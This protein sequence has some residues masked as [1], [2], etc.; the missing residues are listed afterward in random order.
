M[1][2]IVAAM[3]RAFRSCQDLDLDVRIVTYAGQGLGSQGRTPGRHSGSTVAAAGE[4]IPMRNLGV[5]LLFRTSL[6]LRRCSWQWPDSHF[7]F[8]TCSR[9]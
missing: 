6:E 7:L 3:R 8:S 9:L 5:R 1:D 2:W 4:G